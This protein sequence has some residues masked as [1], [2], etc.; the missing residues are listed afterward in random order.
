M[1]GVR[2][3]LE[4]WRAPPEEVVPSVAGALRDVTDGPRIP[5]GC[6]SRNV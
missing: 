3:K 4:A 2:I 1:S 6:A 5:F